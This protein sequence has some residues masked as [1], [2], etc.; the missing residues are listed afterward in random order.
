[1]HYTTIPLGYYYAV[2]KLISYRAR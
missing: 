1:M 2:I